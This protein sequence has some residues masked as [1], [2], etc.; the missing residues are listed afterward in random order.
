MSGYFKRS[1]AR[2]QLSLAAHR[3]DHDPA[4]QSDHDDVEDPGQGHDE[5]PS[6]QLNQ[7]ITES[8][9]E[10][11]AVQA[12]QKQMDKI[13]AF[14]EMQQGNKAVHSIEN[15]PEPRLQSAKTTVRESAAPRTIPREPTMVYNEAQQH[16]ENTAFSGREDPA[17]PDPIEQ[18]AMAIEYLDFTER[19]M[20]RGRKRTYPK[21]TTLTGKGNYQTWSVELISVLQMNS[22]RQIITNKAGALPPSHSQWEDLEALRSDAQSFITASVSAKIRQNLCLTGDPEPERVWNSLRDQYASE[23]IFVAQEGATTIKKMSSTKFNDINDLLEAFKPAWERKIIVRKTLSLQR[24]A[25]V[26]KCMDLISCLQGPEWQIWRSNWEA[27]ISKSPHPT[28]HYRFDAICGELYRASEQASMT[29]KHKAHATSTTAAKFKS[30]PGNSDPTVPTCSYCSKRGHTDE[31]CYK[32]HPELRPTTTK[33]HATSTMEYVNPA[34]AIMEAIPVR[35]PLKAF[36]TKTRNAIKDWACDTACDDFMITS[37][38][39]FMAGTAKPYKALV[40][41]ALDTKVVDGLIG[42]I[43]LTIDDGSANGRTMVLEDTLYLPNLTLNLL[44]QAKLADQGII[45][46]I[47]KKALTFKSPDGTIMGL[48]TRIGKNWFLN[49]KRV[50]Y[51]GTKA[52]TEATEPVKSKVYK[53]STRKSTMNAVKQTQHETAQLAQNS[54]GSSKTLIADEEETMVSP[55]IP[56]IQDGAELTEQFKLKK[57]RANRDTWHRRMCHISMANLAATAKIVDGIDLQNLPTPKE[58]CTHCIIGKAALAP[59]RAPVL[60]RA[61]KTGELVHLDVGGGGKIP[62]G[63]FSNERYWLLDVDDFDGWGE[64][65]FMEHKTQVADRVINIPK[66]YENERELAIQN[67]CSP[68]APIPSSRKQIAAF[69]SDGGGEFDSHRLQQWA[70]RNNLHWFYS[71]PYAHGQNGKVERMMRIVQERT[72]AILN[73]SGLPDGLW[74]EIMKTVMLTRNLTVYNSRRREGQPPITPYQIRFGRKPDLNFLRVIGCNA[75]VVRHPEEI[76]GATQKTSRHL[77]PQAWL[78]KLVGYTGYHGSQ[79]RIWRPSSDGN[80]GEII[81]RQSVIFVEGDDWTL[82]NNP[83]LPKPAIPVENRPKSRFPEPQADTIMSDD[84]ELPEELLGKPGEPQEGTLGHRAEPAFNVDAA[85]PAGAIQL[86][87]ASSDSDTDESVDSD[88]SAGADDPIPYGKISQR[89][90]DELNGMPWNDHQVCFTSTIPRKNRLLVRAYATSTNIMKMNQQLCAPSPS[91]GDLPN[92]PP[93]PLMQSVDSKWLID[94]K[95]VKQAQQS[96]LWP[97]WHRAMLAEVGQF[98][99]MQIWR[100]TAP[101]TREENAKILTGKWVF[102]LKIDAEG[103]PLK[104]KARWVARGFEQREDLDYDKTFASTGRYETLRILLAVIAVMKLFTAHIDVNMAYLNALLKEK[105]YMHYPDGLDRSYNG[106]VCMLLRSIYG[107]KQSAAN[108]FDTLGD[109]LMTKGFVRSASDPCLYIQRNQGGAGKN[110]VVFI[111]VYVDDMLIAASSTSLLNKTKAMISGKWSTSDLGPLAHY[112][113]VKVVHD[114]QEGTLSMSQKTYI[115]RFTKAILGEDRHTI[116]PVTPIT[117]IPEREKTLTAG[118]KEVRSYQSAMGSLNYAG[119]VTR[120]DLSVGLSML[121]QFLTNPNQDHEEQARKSVGYAGKTSDFNIKFNTQ[122]KRGLW[123][124]VDASFASSED[125]KSRTGYVF[126]YAGAPIA[127]KSQ[128]QTSTAKSSAEAEYMALS[129]AGSE[130]I[131]LNRLLEDLG[132]G[133]KGPIP[134]FSDS[135]SAIC[136]AENT[137]THG[138]SKHIDVHWHWIREQIDKKAIELHHVKGTENIADGLTKPLAGPLFRQFVQSLGFRTSDEPIEEPGG[139]RPLAEKPLN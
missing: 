119:T 29:K 41:T 125:R 79:Y 107:L 106:K 53:T 48:G 85:E 132:C 75:F 99:A 108:W 135:V 130:A 138:R 25:E 117:G 114:R 39:H 36:A 3:D 70:K 86:I 116:K 105:L 101:P 49:V 32:K 5:D 88:Y 139:A 90:L 37:P 127:W 129:I 43:M 111:F 81:V 115:D 64:V 77:Q 57:D 40:T 112:L 93:L 109:F 110:E 60:H 97:W 18:E 46:E 19:Q 66:R 12:L 63:W 8:T 102:K 89:E 137:K 120:P 28:D 16:R 61:T 38:N 11:P 54:P 30:K 126:F 52:R 68:H 87:D 72:R 23:D 83:D 73:D 47:D 134:I 62:K 131:W 44:S 65:Q 15:D 34:T 50:H 122:D 1:D 118:P 22:L 95:T 27:T 58:R 14:M 6:D 128:Q 98:E 2:K 42:D 35:V 10:S 100:L 7:G 45:A 31:K 33:S 21:M 76:K 71:A 96:P 67:F 133:T 80:G 113:S 84:D 123:G 51:G 9:G 136:M 17:P 121:S 24:Q 13:L 103:L 74:P 104:F 4:D 59:R 82:Y 78:G 92:L 91:L 55:E 56:R 124:H 94:P 20:K 69:Q 26:E